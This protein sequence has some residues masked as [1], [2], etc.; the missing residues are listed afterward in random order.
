MSDKTKKEG[1]CRYMIKF[2]GYENGS[3]VP[4]KHI[5]ITTE[6][7]LE[8]IAKQEDVTVSAVIKERIWRQTNGRIRAERIYQTKRIE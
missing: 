8:E 1:P 3:I 7:P 2:L 5:E 4:P 6:Q